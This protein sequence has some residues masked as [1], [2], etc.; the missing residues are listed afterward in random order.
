MLVKGS[1]FGRNVS[2]YELPLAKRSDL[3]Q[4]PKPTEKIVR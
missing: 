4:S 3:G 2:S 1:V